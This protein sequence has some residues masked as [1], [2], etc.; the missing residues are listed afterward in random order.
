M[1]RIPPTVPLLALAATLV[2]GA[3][4]LGRA[5]AAAP[6]SRR[7]TPVVEAI[8][9][10][11]PAVVGVTAYLGGYGQGVGSGV[12]IHPAGYVVTSAHV[13]E[14]AQSVSVQPFRQRTDVRATVV[15]ND[16]SRDLALLRIEGTREWPYVTLCPSRE[17]L[18][19]E[20]AIAV[21]APHGLDD[22]ITVGVVSAKGR[23]AKVARGVT[24][25]DLIQTDASI[26]TGNSGGPLINLDGE[27][28]GI[29]ASI[30][31]RAAGIAFAVPAEQ[32]GALLERGLREAMPARN[33]VRDTAPTPP[34]REPI[35]APSPAPS[36]P[37]AAVPPRA[38]P[39]VR[40]SEPPREPPPRVSVAP[41]LERAP[42][43]E[44][45]IE[46]PP[47]AERPE[48]EPLLPSD[49]G[50][51][52]AD[53]GKRVVVIS[54]RPGLPAALA[55]LERGDV[56]LDVDGTPIE[57]TDDLVI[58]L[59]TSYAGRRFFVSLRRGVTT[60]NLVVTVPR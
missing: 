36:A 9:H 48:F 47:L 59:A 33:P 15:R 24:L 11:S 5:T 54:V 39:P 35:P 38:E 49:L 34:T 29:I 14:G 4:S 58:S 6:S 53:D 2:V 19:G 31:P 46:E 45:W 18:L 13:I 30:L 26:N 10:A 27:V 3:F 16:P 22:T 56:L 60:R 41:P 52:V 42:A 20:T 23:P 57:S 17:V 28:I 43:P 25:R 1:R 50:F 32:V 51:E 12:I 40:A 55:G 37:L 8:E 44:P 21:G 7:R